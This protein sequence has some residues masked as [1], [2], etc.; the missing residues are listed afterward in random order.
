MNATELTVHAVVFKL[1]SQH[2]FLHDPS[3]VVL[4]LLLVPLHG[5][6]HAVG[7]IQAG[8]TSQQELQVLEAG[9]ALEAGVAL[10]VLKVL[11][12]VQD[13]QAYPAVQE[14]QVAQD[15][16]AVPVSQAAQ[17]SQVV[18][19]FQAVQE[20]R[21]AQVFQVNQVVQESQAVQVFRVIQAVQEN[22][23]AQALEVFQAAP[24]SLADQVTVEVSVTAPHDPLDQ[25]AVEDLTTA[26]DQATHQVVEPLVDVQVVEHQLA[27]VH[28]QVAVVV[29]THRRVMEYHQRRKRFR[30]SRLL[31]LV[32]NG[33]L[34]IS[35]TV[36]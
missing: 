11:Q 4:S 8:D 18:Q 26:L 1:S 3:L 24:V 23:V 19:D 10:L 15:F 30:L 36:L 14:N 29:V 9:K 16:Q 27:A 21:V 6:I 2:G 33:N 13:L 7:E 35:V 17:V 20:N 22:Q 28:D 34:E 31:W 32:V 5:E 12:D 25:L